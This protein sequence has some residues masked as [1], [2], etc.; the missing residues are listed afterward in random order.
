MRHPSSRLV[1]S[2]VVPVALVSGCGDGESISPVE[3]EQPL[4]LPE[5]PEGWNEI[6]PG[7]DTICSRGTE[8]AFFVRPGKVNRLVVDFIG[9]GACWN[10][11][12]C[13]FAGA[14]FEEDVESVREAVAANVPVGMYDHDDPVNPVKDWYHVVIPYCTGDV[15]WGDAVKTYGEGDSAVTIHHKGSVNARAVLDWVYTNFSAPEH[16]LV[17]GCSAGS[18]GSILWAPHVMQHYSSSQVTQFGDSG[19][20]VITEEFFQD[21]FPS[22]N[23]EQAFPAFI[24][25]LD[26]AKVDIQGKKLAD[27]YSAIGN[28]FPEQ[29]VSQYNTAFDEN[30]TFYFQ[31]MGGS[32]AAE[33]SEKMHASIADIESRTANFADFLP[34]GEQHCI[35]PY[36]NY[37]SVSAGGKLL[38]DWLGDMIDRGPVERLS[39]GDACE[40]ETP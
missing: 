15:H 25:E 37:Y 11:T 1:R 16:V 23:A 29:R 36:A 21:S 38:V 4:V 18:Y 32:G 9:G 12:T 14:I 27:L 2:L 40:G 24:P 33:W 3:T 6:V 31:A 19:A 22:W 39:C 10:A 28:Y 7:G 17:T 34:S 26:P 35:V 8:Y 13:G 5:L 20:G 30:Q